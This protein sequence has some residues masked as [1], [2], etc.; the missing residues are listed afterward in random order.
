M[1]WRVRGLANIGEQR[2]IKRF[3]L[4]PIY[5]SGECRWLETVYIR[6]ELVW[7][8][9]FISAIG[10]TPCITWRDVEFVESEEK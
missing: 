5:V 6:Q 2:T 3:A 7:G 8:Y 4:F 9:E 10:A 1:R